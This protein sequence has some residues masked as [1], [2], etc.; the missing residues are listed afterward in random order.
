MAWRALKVSYGE[1][2]HIW[3]V[4]ANILNGQLWTDGIIHL[5]LWGETTSLNCWHERTY[6]SSPRWYEFGERRWNDIDRGKRTWRETCPSAT[7]STTNPTWIDP[8]ANLFLR[9]ERPATNRLSHGTARTDDKCFVLQLP[10]SNGFVFIISWQLRLNHDKDVW[11][12][13]SFLTT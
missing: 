12:L 11:R 7:L 5:F 2:L 9:G 13:L 6:C 8:T 10:G 1:D 3:R 4:V